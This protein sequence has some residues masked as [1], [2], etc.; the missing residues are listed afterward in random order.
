[1]K[2]YLLAATALSFALSNNFVSFANA[3]IPQVWVDI[4]APTD[5]DR[6]EDIVINL[7]T[8]NCSIEYQ[9]YDTKTRQLTLKLRAK[10]GYQFSMEK[11]SDAQVTGAKYI[12][13]VKKENSTL[14]NWTIEI[15][16]SENNSTYGWQQDSIGKWYKNSDGSYIA[17][18]WYQDF[19]GAWYYFNE[20][21]YT[22][23][24]TNAPD[25]RFVDGNGRWVESVSGESKKIL[26]DISNWI[27]GD[28]W[29]DG[30][31]NFSYFEEDGK[32][33]TGNTIDIDFAYQIFKEKYKK[34]A[35][36]DT[37]INALPDDFSPLKTAWNKLSTESDK[38]YKYYETNGIKQSGT[39]V[40]TALFVQYREA[41]TDSV[42]EID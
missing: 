14:L 22:L 19:D 33:S 26:F 4:S 15:N 40:D 39:A 10:N 30:F 31:C 8:A 35:S 13:A 25:G 6:I 17:N 29:N 2:K 18:Q 1:M 28:I 9:S 27:I 21:G 7:K 37:Y 11:A 32:D 23:V 16:P 34:K 38:L 3:E 41:F 20:S 42:Y 12:H 5:T 24:N 36:Y